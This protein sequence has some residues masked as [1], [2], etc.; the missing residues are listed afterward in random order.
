MEAMI[1]LRRKTKD[2]NLV[3]LGGDRF[4]TDQLA[5]RELR[6]LMLSLAR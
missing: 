4:I 1:V 3:I 5:C 2:R 6:T